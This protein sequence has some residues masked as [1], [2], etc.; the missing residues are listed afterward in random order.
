MGHEQAMNEAFARIF[1]VHGP[2][3]RFQIEPAKHL[4]AG[5]NVILQAPTGSGKTKAA[6]FPYLFA[7]VDGLDLPQKLL[8]C[9]PMRVLARSFYEDLKNNTTHAEFD[10]RLQTGEQQDDRKLEGDITFATIDQVLS[11]FLNI[12]YSLSLRQGNVNAGT[13]VSSYLVFDEFHLLDPGSTLPTALEMLR[14]LKGVT[15]F[16]LMTATFSREML[17]RLASLLDAEVVTA[18]NDEL[19]RIPTQKD[20]VR[21]FHRI[22]APL[23]AEAVLQDHST[24]SIAICNTVERAQDLFEELRAQADSGT[25][26]ILIHSRFLREH[27]RKKEDA[28]RRFFSK[29]GDKGGSIILVATQ[30]IEVGLD[31]TCQ[32]M[33][34][35]VAPASTILQ[36]AGR[37]ARFEGEKGDVYIYQVPLNRKDEPNYAPYLGEQATLSGKTWEALLLFAGE[38]IDFVAEQRLVNQVHAETDGRMLDGLEQARYAH[39]QEIN[40]AIGQ[41]EM[42]LARDLIRNDD[43]VTVL[44]HPSPSVIENPHD[45]EGFSLFFGTLH[46]QFKEWK[47]ASLPNEEIPW[48]L[49]YPQEQDG[50]EG[51]D[52]AIHYDWIEVIKHQEIKRSAI[53]VVNPRLVRY[54]SEMGFRFARG[55]GFQS[56][57]QR[58]QV[59]KARREWQRGYRRE[60]YQEHVQKMLAVYRDRLSREIAYAANRLEQQM[61]LPAGSLE[62]AVRLTIALHDVGKM[63]LRWQGWAHEWQKRIGAPVSEDYMLAHTDYNSDDPR[64][65][66]VEAEMP[67]SRP[68]HAA[69]GAVAVFRVLHQLLGTPGQDDPRFKLM[70]A[71]FTAIARHHSPRADSYRGFTLH[72]AAG[73]ALA[74][75][76][77]GLDASGQANKVLVTSKRPQ[78]ITSLMVQPDARDE[79][80]AYF[81]IV[82]ALR[83]ADQGAA[84]NE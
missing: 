79:L 25:Q 1:Q 60:S 71:I 52:R 78:P 68:P 29:D 43:S 30:V 18:S 21:W 50:W 73:K 66:S 36:R 67:S 24:R 27:R 5:R 81:L 16:V 7:R 28:V 82:R 72:Q 19:Q 62:R 23:T 80:L 69:E 57:F 58:G 10:A 11:S 74:Q 64:H 65:R 77:A 46:G 61:D 20:K 39:R 9:V 51:E 54:D 59:E 38:N 53:H 13:V 33:H 22:D 45:L 70:K 4:L 2:Y 49:K 35:E 55:G 32:V 6:L 63:D 14:M 56:P 37:C 26:V 31:I 83:L 48:L 84:V 17:D 40:R 15:P 3:G 42:G 75:V 47:E 8:Y 34:T 12:P 41:Q 44:V 76:L